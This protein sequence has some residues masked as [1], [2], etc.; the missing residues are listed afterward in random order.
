M[1]RWVLKFASYKIKDDIFDAVITRKKTI[2]TRPRN[3]ESREDYSKIKV[4]DKLVLYSLDSGKK[5][6]KIV[7]FVHVYNSVSL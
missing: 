1:A 6:E 2:E 3:P 7:T 4:G 5:I